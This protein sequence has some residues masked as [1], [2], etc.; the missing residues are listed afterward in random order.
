MKTRRPAVIPATIVLLCL[1]GCTF[2]SSSQ[3]ISAGQV[4]QLQKK[5]VATIIKVQNVVID[6]TKGN[7]GQY[8]GA[9]IGGAAAMPSG[10]IGGTGDA[11]AVAGASVFGAIAGQAIEEYVT[12]KQAQRITLQMPNGDVREIVQAS[13]PVFQVGDKVDVIQGPYGDRLEMALDF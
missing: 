7:M 10:G 11:L 6:G 13:P 1:S 2:P 12:R 5:T 4:G 9:V 3:T 8:G